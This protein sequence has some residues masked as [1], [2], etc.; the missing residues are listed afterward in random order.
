LKIPSDLEDEDDYGDEEGNFEK[1][2]AL[3]DE[4]DVF[5]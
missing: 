5:G 2:G 4:N 1:Q 3:V